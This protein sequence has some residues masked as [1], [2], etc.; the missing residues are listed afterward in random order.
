V[1][2]HVARVERR[3]RFLRPGEAL[4]DAAL[5]IDPQLMPAITPDDPVAT[6]A[7]VNGFIEALSGAYGTVDA[8]GAVSAAASP[9]VIPKGPAVW[10]AELDEADP[11][12]EL[13]MREPDGIDWGALKAAAARLPV[14]LDV[15]PK[16]AKCVSGKP[17]GP[18]ARRLGVLNL[19]RLM[20]PGPEQTS[21]VR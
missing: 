9:T 2:L 3:R 8:D 21:A 19:D 5:A 10:A 15:I 11:E 16:Q 13:P 4:D 18:L 6:R 1:N 20:K 12:E 7:S 14:D 17:V